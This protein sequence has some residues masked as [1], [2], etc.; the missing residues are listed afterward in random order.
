MKKLKKLMGLNG[1]PHAAAKAITCS[2]FGRNCADIQQTVA[3][4]AE[5]AQDKAR[6]IAKSLAS[7]NERSH[8]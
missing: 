2:A 4:H 1:E 8:T 3:E 5:A 7:L 6:S